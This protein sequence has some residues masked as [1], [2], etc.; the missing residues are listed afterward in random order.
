M[1]EYS[2]RAQATV[3]QFNNAS[4]LIRGEGNAIGRVRPSVRLFSFC[5]LN[6]L[7]SDLDFCV[8][9]CIGYNHGSLEIENHGHGTRD[10]GF[11]DQG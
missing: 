4:D 3:T 2:R 11:C 8:Y 7:T 9:Q 10:R 1:Y 5:P 6:Q